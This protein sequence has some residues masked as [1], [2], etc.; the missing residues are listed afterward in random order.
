[1]N[2]FRTGFLILSKAD[3]L[4]QTFLWG[5]EV[6]LSASWDV[7]QRLCPCPLDSSSIPTSDVTTTHASR[8]SKMS[9][10]GEGSVL[11]LKV[12]QKSLKIT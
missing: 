10:G 1:M 6:L 9:S 3:F 5:S 4:D 12:K 11:T 8:Q 7:W 2:F